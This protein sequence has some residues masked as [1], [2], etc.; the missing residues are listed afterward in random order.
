MH[1]IYELAFHKRLFKGRNGPKT[2]LII[3]S[4]FR[5]PPDA[6]AASMDSARAQEGRRKASVFWPCSV[7]EPSYDGPK[8]SIPTSRLIPSFD[9]RDYLE[10]NCQRVHFN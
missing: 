3:I 4:L 8:K 2:N 1:E 9:I 10:K 7:G 6:F 5:K